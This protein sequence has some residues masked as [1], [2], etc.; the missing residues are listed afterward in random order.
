[1]YVEDGVQLVECM[2]SIVLWVQSPTR[3]QLG[4]VLYACTWEVETGGLEAQDH[5]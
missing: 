2:A 1:M 3:H 5:Y 4:V